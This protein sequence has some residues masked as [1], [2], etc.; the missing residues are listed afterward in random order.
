M[1]NTGKSHDLLVELENKCFILNEITN[2]ILEGEGD[3]EYK[4]QALTN[5]IYDCS[6]KVFCKI[7]NINIIPFGK[8]I[9]KW[10]DNNCKIFKNKY[11]EN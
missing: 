5:I 8:K 1:L 2:D 3:L 4:I 7:F 11:L 6:F 9:N 10:F